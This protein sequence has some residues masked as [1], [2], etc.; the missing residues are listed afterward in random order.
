MCIE[1]SKRRLLALLR[2]TDATAELPTVDLWSPRL[3]DVEEDL[4][5]NRARYYDS[6]V[7]RWLSTDP[8]GYSADD[9]DC[10]PYVSSRFAKRS[11]ALIEQVGRRVRE[12]RAQTSASRSGG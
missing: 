3:Y 1:P 5:Y 4:Q 8:L 11:P 7:G 9:G 12:R 2:E 6:S 10:Y